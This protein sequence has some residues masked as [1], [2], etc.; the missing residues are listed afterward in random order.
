M[1]QKI[2]L[3]SG[4]LEILEQQERE[5]LSHLHAVR[6]QK[7]SL[8]AEQKNIQ[9]MH[10]VPDVL[11]IVF[12]ILIR[13]QDEYSMDAP[14]TISHVCQYW[15]QIALAHPPLWSK[16][17][18][19]H[20]N[21]ETNLEQ[22]QTFLA[23]AKDAVSL[24]LVVLHPKLQPEL[25]SG[26]MSGVIEIITANLSRCH[27]LHWSWRNDLFG[28]LMATL[29]HSTS[30]PLLTKLSLCSDAT[31]VDGVDFSSLPNYKPPATFQNLRSLIIQ[32]VRF[33][34]LPRPAYSHLR[35]LEL[36]FSG[37][38][39]DH[40]VH[41]SQFRKVFEETRKLE[42]LSLSNLL[43]RLDM[44]LGEYAW[45]EISGRC[46]VESTPPTPLQNL[47]KLFWHRPPG[48]HFYIFFLF[49]PCP[50]LESLQVV[51]DDKIQMGKRQDFKQRRSFI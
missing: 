8:Y 20:R 14:L 35:T 34:H 47:T 9:S 5:L 29:H 23:R 2:R 41:L 32:D 1:D 27:S 15:R 46:V 17:V 49:F 38:Y 18:V 31:F 37:K 11:L 48:R 28:M 40:T 51:P 13:D 36:A 4:Q 10:L 22:V 21:H 25:A 43:V 7:S 44:T 26:F 12:E 30:F 3:I 6:T 33:E 50:K 39:K 42:E 16:L 24:D 19:G 45:N